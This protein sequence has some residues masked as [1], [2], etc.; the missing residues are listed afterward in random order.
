MCIRDRFCKNVIE[1]V[2]QKSCEVLVQAAIKSESAKPNRVEVS[3][4][5]LTKAIAKSD[6]GLVDVQL[7]IA[8]NLV[9]VGAPA[10][11]IYPEVA[12]R[13]NLSYDIPEHSEVG[14]AVGAAA[15]SVSQRVSG[16]I[17]SP[18]DGIYRIHTP[19]GIQDFSDLDEAAEVATNELETLAQ[20][21]AVASN[22]DE[23]RIE[24]K[25][26]DNIIKG[27]GGQKIF[28]ESQITVSVSGQVK[29]I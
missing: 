18:S 25:R 15:G 26:N 11:P 21:R 8:G 16:L 22:A 1:S 10:L 5:L 20:Q 14:N 28:I 3:D 12:S 6:P 2:I 7:S 19:N 27:L 23:A 24:T 13:L 9:V 17:T 4:Y 29:I